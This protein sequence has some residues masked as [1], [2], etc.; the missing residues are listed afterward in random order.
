M[1]YFDS[2]RNS[3]P[4]TDIVTVAATAADENDKAG[5]DAGRKS[6]DGW[7]RLVDLASWRGIDAG[8]L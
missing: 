3:N 5:C 8:C 1:K 4:I 7:E 6:E 2:N